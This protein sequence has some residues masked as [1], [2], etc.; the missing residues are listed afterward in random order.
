MKEQG[1]RIFH[2]RARGELACFTRPELKVERVSY[3]VMTP[4]AARGLLESILWKP[5]MEWRIHEIEVLAPIRWMSI[6]RNEVNSRASL[7]QKELVADEDRAQRNTVALRDV[8]YV[9]H[10]SIALTARAG[11]GDNLRKFEAMFERRLAK[12]QHH[13]APFFGCRE[14][15]AAVEPAHGWPPPIDQGVDRPLGWMFYDFDWTGFSSEHSHRE[16]EAGSPLF[17]EARLT[18][19]VLR[20][21]SR[22]V[23]RGAVHPGGAAT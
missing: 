22:D 12:G 21:P 3:E 17:F 11:Q 1:S 2:I 13:V 10:A 15:F 19:G 20:V 16:S 6:R 23:V 7:G 9:V 18:S 5:A 4:S 14:F 8:D